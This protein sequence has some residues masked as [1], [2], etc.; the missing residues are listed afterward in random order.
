MI[1]RCIPPVRIDKQLIRAQVVDGWLLGNVTLSYWNHP[2]G[3]SFSVELWY[4]FQQEHKKFGYSNLEDA[5]VDFRILKTFVQPF[6]LGH[7]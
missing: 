7:D 5:F 6:R 2:P 3:E 1:R 4:P